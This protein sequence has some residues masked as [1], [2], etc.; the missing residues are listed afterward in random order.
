MG[1]REA[2]SL[3]AAPWG[4]L[5]PDAALVMLKDHRDL[6]IEALS[7]CATHVYNEVKDAAREILADD[8]FK[9]V[10][11]NHRIPKQN[12]DLGAVPVQPSGIKINAQPRE[13]V[14]TV[15]DALAAL[16][17]SGGSR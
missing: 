16:S 8:E 12:I 5:T 3:A 11:R 17:A 15:D 4:R 1:R 13:V 6:A 10:D 2:A 9:R 7:K 14:V